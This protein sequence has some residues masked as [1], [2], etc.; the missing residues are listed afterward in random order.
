MID[1]TALSLPVLIGAFLALAA[2]VLWAGTR[3]ARL[4]DRLADL[5]GWGEA[6]T[7]AIFLGAITSA[8]GSVTSVA[9]AAKGHPDLAI[10][11]AIGG[12]AAQTVFLVPADLAYR[13]ANL[14]HAAAS[15]SNMISGAVLMVLLTLLLIA[16]V[17]PEVTLF[18]IHPITP[19]LL[20]TYILG[21]AVSD[22]AK[23][24]PMWGPQQTRD[25]AEDVPDEPKGDRRTVF[26]LFGL[27]ILLGLLVGLAGYFIAE[28][29]LA[30]A[31]KTD[32]RKG[33]VGAL[34]TS[35]STSTPEL[36]TTL[37]AVRRGALTLAIGGI[38]GGNAFDVLF[39][40]FSD[41]AYRDGSIYHAMEPDQL[42]L[43]QLSILM[44]AVLLMGL[45]Q[46]ERHG[47]ANIG[48]E[49]IALVGLYAGGV[50]L[51]VWAF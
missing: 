40:A 49:S 41:I 22:N 5:T 31:E 43:I 15:L 12:I 42:F 3:L 20:I 7:G 35:V 48:F 38:L 10:S 8:A 45:L 11:N 30:I 32:I 44:T 47:P 28:T 36:V 4:A 37:A 51:L 23:K 19:L 39:S 21:M 24:A 6:I 2:V 34:M 16:A 27:V 29:G 26:K 14:E 18:A 17:L 46:R 33:V 9:A 50:A 13:R 25:T 1:F